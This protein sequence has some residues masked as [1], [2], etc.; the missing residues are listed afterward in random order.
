[1]STPTSLLLDFVKAHQNCIGYSKSVAW[2]TTSHSLWRNILIKKIFS[3][4]SPFC[5][6]NRKTCL[7]IFKWRCSFINQHWSGTVSY[8]FPGR[9][10]GTGR[11][12]RQVSKRNFRGIFLNYLTDF[13]KKKINIIAD[14]SLK[15]LT[16]NLPSTFST[17]LLLCKKKW[18]K[19]GN[20]KEKAK[21]T[22]LILMKTNI[23]PH[24]KYYMYFS[25]QNLKK[26]LYP[27]KS[28]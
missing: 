14:Y 3:Y 9:N 13:R 24:M 4:P 1:M 22:I 28:N 16:Q 26:G 7:G 12:R 10:E 5:P 23:Q 19:T 15:I 21:N 11:G 8:P 17:T 25:S 6:W 20:D 27:G 18:G 2:K